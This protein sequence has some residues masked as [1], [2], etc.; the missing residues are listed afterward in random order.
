MNKSLEQ[1]AGK[2]G[3]TAHEIRA[4]IELLLVKQKRLQEK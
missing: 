2:M 1:L 3:E 4:S